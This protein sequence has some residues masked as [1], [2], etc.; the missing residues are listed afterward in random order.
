MIQ[1]QD[2]IFFYFF[3][4]T[5]KE[6]ESKWEH[7]YISFSIKLFSPMI[8]TNFWNNKITIDSIV[9]T[10]K[11]TQLVSIIVITFGN[12]DVFIKQPTIFNNNVMPSKGVGTSMLQRSDIVLM[13]WRQATYKEKT[14]TTSYD[15][16]PKLPPDATAKDN[17]SIG[18]KHGMSMIMS[19]YFCN[20]TIF[21]F[22]MFLTLFVLLSVININMKHHS[23][24][25]LSINTHNIW[26]P[27]VKISNA[28]IDR[29][30]Q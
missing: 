19:I 26:T 15:V 20:D 5:T 10:H 13:K 16:I 1:Q 18:L 27:I 17:H 23:S 6:K 3:P 12:G 14:N 28:T 29:Q 8:F 30:A 22:E 24:V 4:S 7:N 9:V 11:F 25:Y 21:Q 2:F